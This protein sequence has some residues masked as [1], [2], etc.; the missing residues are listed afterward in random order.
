M[1][2]NI[3][4]KIDV[5]L[6]RYPELREVREDIHQSFEMMKD[7]YRKGG[8]LLIAGNGGSAADAEHLVGELMKDFKLKRGLSEKV[9]EHMRM[10]DPE[11]GEEL[12]HQLVDGLPAIN[13]NNHFALH[14]AYLND[15]K[16][17]K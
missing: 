17:D 3:I 15:V 8:K 14:S 5:L 16:A 7:C 13:L 9:K 6:Q 1:N 2:I 10:I 12:G 4:G 11:I